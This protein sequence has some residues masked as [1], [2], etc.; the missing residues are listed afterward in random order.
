MMNQQRN[1]SI[2]SEK[3]YTDVL[4]RIEE[5]MDMNRTSIE[6][7]ELDVL[8]TLVEN[9][10]D[11]HFPMDPPDPIETIKFFMQQRGMKQSDL[12]PIFGSRTKVSEVLNGKRT[13]T[14]KMI[15]ALHTDLGIPAEIL[16]RDGGSL[17]AVPTGIDIERFPV[18]EMAKRGWIR[19]SSNLKDCTEEIVQ[20]L[21]A[22]IGGH[23]ALPQALFRQSARANISTDIH[24]LQAWCLYVLCEARRAGLGGI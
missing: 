5:L 17:P 2:H 24:S 11:Q 22:C 18:T 23:E 7:E 14:L 21:L 6:D 3:D 10:E 16:I 19:K 1:R 8:A 13:L 15:R 20:D 4:A 9:Y 12:V